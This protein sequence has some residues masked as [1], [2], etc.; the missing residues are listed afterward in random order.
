MGEPAP[1]RILADWPRGM[2]VAV[3]QAY[4]TA[5][6]RGEHWQ[7]CMNAAEAAYIAS[8]GDPAHSWDVTK[9]ILA[10]VRREHPDWFWRPARERIERQEAHWKGR[11]IWPPPLAWSARWPQRLPG[12]DQRQCAI[13]PRADK[14]G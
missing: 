10:V 2:V 12:E 11:G 5:S 4:R 14:W 6:G 8:G 3:A 7:V 1:G 13:G 9:N